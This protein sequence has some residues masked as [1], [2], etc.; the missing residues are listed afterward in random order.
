[1]VTG[2]WF[3]GDLT[4]CN[5]LVKDSDKIK[6]IN[7][8]ID[9]IKSLN[10]NIHMLFSGHGNHLFYNADFHSIMEQSKINHKGN[11]PPLKAKLVGA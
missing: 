7:R 5:D 1:M 11:H 3:L 6:S 4:D 10:Y 9:I 8:V 2:D